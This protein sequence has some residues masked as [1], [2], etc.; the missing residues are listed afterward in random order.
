MDEADPPSATRTRGVQSPDAERPKS[1]L[2][3]LY[4]ARRSA[5]IRYLTARSGS[6]VVAEDLVQDLYFRLSEMS[7]SDQ[8]AVRHGAAFLYRLAGNLFL[9]RVKQQQ[10]RLAR[11]GAWRSVN[12]TVAGSEDVAGVPPADDAAWARQKLE[13]VVAAV[14]QMPPACRRAFELHK[15]QGLS[16][17]ET[18]S[19]MGISRS[20]VEKHISAALKRLM[21][22]VGW[23]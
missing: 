7:P 8:E 11:D 18:A 13:R 20:A 14:Q 19:A 22:D 1:E 3:E 2:L 21:R 15:L 9:D 16:H 17:A 23:P 10:R 5:L 6:P 4:F 12:V